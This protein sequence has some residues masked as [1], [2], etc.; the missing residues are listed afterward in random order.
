MNAKKGLSLA[1][2]GAMVASMLSLP[3]MAAEN[4]EPNFPDAEGSWASESIDRW[5]AAGVVSGDENGNFNPTATLTRAE[6]AQIFVNM[7][8]LTE[9]APNVYADLRGDEWYADAILKCTAAGIMQGDGVSANPLSV[10]SRQETMV[11]FGRAMGVTPEANPD[12]SSFT[13]GAAVA[14]WAA[15]YMAPLAEM[16]I[17]SG[18]GDGSIQP[19]MNIDRASTMAL[20]DKAIV[21]YI[22]EPGAYTVENANGFV[23]V[24]AAAGEVE[25]SGQVAGVVVAA[26]S[27]GSTVT[28][29]DLTADSLK[30]DG[31]AEVSVEGASKVDTMT[32]NAAGSVEIAQG[33]TVDT[34]EVNAAASLTNSGTVSTLEA[35]DVATVT[36][37][38]TISTLTANDA[39]KVDNK[40]TVSKA[41]INADNV[42]LDGTKP[43]TVDVAEGTKNPTNSQGEEIKDNTTSGGSTGS[44]STGPVV[45]YAQIVKAPLVD[46]AADNAIPSEKLANNYSVSGIV[47]GDTINVTITARDLMMHNN[48]S[49]VSDYWVGFGIEAKEGNTYYA[50]FGSVPADLGSPVESVAGRTYEEGG[51]TYNTVY[52]GL[53]DE[54]LSKGGYVVVKN[55]ESTTT[56]IVSFDVTFKSYATTMLSELPEELLKAYDDASQP[57]RHKTADGLGLT[58][59]VSG[60]TMTLTGETTTDKLDATDTTTSNG[61]I[62]YGF[63]VTDPDGVIKKIKTGVSTYALTDF[64]VAGL[65]KA[66]LLNAK[67]YD[68]TAKQMLNTSYEVQ[69]LD[70]NDRVQD[71]VTLTFNA[72]GVTIQGKNKVEFLDDQNGSLL[73]SVMVEA[74]G[75]VAEG[76]FP[77]APTKDNMV[78]AGWYYMDNSDE[79]EFT[80]ST[81][82]SANTTVYAKYVALT[83]QNVE[84]RPDGVAGVAPEFS[85]SEEYAKAGATVTSGSG[86]GSIA[87]DQKAVLSYVSN[88]DNNT[89]KGYLTHGDKLYVGFAFEAPKDAAELIV[90]ST[91]YQGV[92]AENLTFKLGSESTGNYGDI[93]KKDDKTYYID[94]LSFATTEG[95]AVE[96]SSFTYT[97]TWKDSTGKV[98]AYTGAT[99]T[100]STTPFVVNSEDS[101][102][103]A[104]TAGIKQI[105][106]AD[107]V[108]LSSN[109]GVT[110]P[111]GTTVTIPKETTLTV[112]EGSK[113]TVNGTL[114]GTD[115]T[116]TLV[117][118]TMSGDMKAGTY[119]WRDSAWKADVA[120]VLQWALDYQY[121]P[122][123]TYTH[124]PAISGTTV[125]YTGSQ[126][127]FTKKGGDDENPTR[128]TA[129]LARLLGAIWRIDEGKSVT[130]I[131]YDSKDYTWESESGRKGSNWENDEDT[132]LVSAVAT[133]A[134]TGLSDGSESFTFTINGETVTLE[135]KISDVGGAG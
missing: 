34:V 64:T 75:Q 47:N 120:T 114:K 93:F 57:I 121:D 53:K 46:Q 36:N 8:G 32:V 18:S 94:Y 50:G 90:T 44:G 24:N 65:D 19:G 82:V 25:L 104:I 63:N 15:G 122:A 111:E 39:V 107:S 73:A 41:E 98:I 55:G 61:Y 78:F 103:E 7:F 21:S 35:N 38:G 79:K 116:S 31:T 129:D 127:D 131:S 42:V 96:D 3:A 74:N 40:G 108:T 105:T 51:K 100:R 128:A 17:I 89:N 66:M 30:V 76:S 123:Y 95:G 118:G 88:S 69:L 54:D 59:A 83:D 45:S 117:L 23:V 48:T 135:L 72:A 109:D 70:A 86:T 110:I 85:Y 43:S 26:G 115:T 37:N 29:K 106:L 56:Y 16:G 58:A 20:L 1:L 87:V 13:D 101:L 27:A 133:K 91:G 77:A 68:D 130:T 92:E 9:K 134:E 132:T 81:S 125:T 126:D 5:G 99:V 119:T 112:A 10:I 60:N 33:V 80:K 113:L 12:M 62:L 67:F 22:S 2:S 97:F 14:D 11:M 49:Q 4:T 84:V 52:F 71:T 28:A 102:K 124:T 6:L